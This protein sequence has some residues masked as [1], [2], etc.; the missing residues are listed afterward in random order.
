MEYRAKQRILNWGI[1]SGRK[2]LKEMLKDL[3]H[4]GNANQNNSETPSYTSSTQH[5]DEDQKPKLQHM[6]VKMWTK[7]NI[8]LLLV[9]VHT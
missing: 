4:Q 1:S 2:A 7:G 5:N 3:S 9:G 6:L 8:P